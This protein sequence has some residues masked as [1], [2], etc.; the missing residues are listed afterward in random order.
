MATVTPEHVKIQGRGGAMPLILVL[1]SW[2][3]GA[4]AFVLFL[5]IFLF[6]R[7]RARK[8]VDPEIRANNDND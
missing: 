8:V 3:M 4:T 5:L 1:L 6:S 7:R 2:G